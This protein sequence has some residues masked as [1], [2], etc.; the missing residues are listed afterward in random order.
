[1]KKESLPQVNAKTTFRK[2]LIRKDQMEPQAWQGLEISIP[3]VKRHLTTS[4][5]KMG[6]FHMR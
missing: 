2:H 1:M 5:G 4:F 6:W 3:L